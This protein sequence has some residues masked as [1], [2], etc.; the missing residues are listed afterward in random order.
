VVDW[1]KEYKAKIAAR[2][3]NYRKEKKEKLAERDDKIGENTQSNL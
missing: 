3:T 1:R 2:Q